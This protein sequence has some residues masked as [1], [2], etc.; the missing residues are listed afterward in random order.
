MLSVSIGFDLGSSSAKALRTARR[1][2]RLAAAV[3]RRIGTRRRAGGRVEHDPEEIV[4]ATLGVL[5]TA[6]AAASGGKREAE[7]LP[8]GIATQRST[9]LFWDRDGGRPLT[10]AYSW[11]DLRGA[12]LCARLR[13]LT[14]PPGFSGAGDLD[15]AV[16]ARTGLRLSPH[17]S[18]AKIAWALAH[19]RGL[20]RG[21]AAGRIL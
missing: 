7:A 17:Y 15:A 6:G 3:R 8:L 5:R 2:E 18:A 16:A 12:P 1:G 20:R 10:P 11:Q 13:R 4:R 14:S 9:V 21:V 19:V